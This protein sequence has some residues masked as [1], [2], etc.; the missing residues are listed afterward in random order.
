MT[1]AFACYNKNPE[2]RKSGSSGG[3]YGLL[4]GKILNEGGCVFAACY[5]ESLTVRH[6]EITSVEQL[7]E[8]QGAKYVE[9]ALG[10]TFRQV[11]ERVRAG[12]PT[13]FVGTPCQCAGLLRF[14]EKPYE[15]LLCVDLI[16]HGVP[17]PLVWRAYL[18]SEAAKGDP[19]QAIH[20]RDKTSGWKNYS[21]RIERQSGRCEVIRAENHPY[22]KGFLSNLYL[23]P[24]CYFCQWKGEQHKADITLGDYWGV[25]NYHPELDDDAGISLVLCHTQK[26]E[27]ALRAIRSELRCKETDLEKATAANRHYSQSAY[28]SQNRQ[29][30]FFLLQRNRDFFQAM[31][32]VTAKGVLPGAGRRLVKRLIPGA[33]VNTEA[34]KTKGRCCG[35]TA[36]AALCPT[37]AIRI[38]VDEEGFAYPSVDAALCLSCGRCREGCPADARLLPECTR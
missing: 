35:C 37:N 34:L 32:M 12:A 14:L 24:S 9:S 1:R 13:L 33:R 4:A 5:E 22:E 16:C 2:G 29:L 30:F 15:N 28:L 8:S 10:D 6:W 20:M 31:R 3:V 38:Q 25:S 21:W 26:G 7:A 11:R 19:V 17:S 27:N 18:H 36:C 23:R